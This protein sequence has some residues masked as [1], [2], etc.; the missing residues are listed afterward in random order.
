MLTCSVTCGNDDAALVG[1]HVGGSDEL[2]LQVA[3]V[4]DGGSALTSAGQF[5]VLP[6]TAVIRRVPVGT[7]HRVMRSVKKRRSHPY[8]GR[9]NPRG[10]KST[11]LAMLIKN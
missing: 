2:V 11:T 1:G 6:H 7:E 9:V 10:V 8:M 5:S 3:A 4:C